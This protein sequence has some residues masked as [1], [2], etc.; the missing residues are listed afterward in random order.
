MPR[1]ERLTRPQSMKVSPG[2]RVN[3]KYSKHATG[4]ALRSIKDATKAL[5]RLRN[6]YPELFWRMARCLNEEG[7]AQGI[8]YRCGRIMD[9]AACPYCLLIL[10]VRVLELFKSRFPFKRKCWHV[11]IVDSDNLIPM[12]MLHQYDQDEFRNRLNYVASS[13]GKKVHALGQFEYAIV[14]KTID[15][16]EKQYWSPHIHLIVGGPNSQCFI[17]ACREE[18]RST[19][20]T[21]RPVMQQRLNTVGDMLICACYDFKSPYV[22]KRNDVKLTRN[23]SVELIDFRIEKA[24]MEML[25]KKGVNFYEACVSVSSYSRLRKWHEENVGTWEFEEVLTRRKL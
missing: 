13:L 3:R 9:S 16:E 22:K 7:C 8:G 2:Y 24:C 20:F 23:Q 14:G 19:K 10:R 15:H 12:G 4:D 21:R 17:R 5:R 18:F 6:E 25:W 11:T 1:R